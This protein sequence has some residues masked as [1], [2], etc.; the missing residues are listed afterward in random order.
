DSSIFYSRLSLEAAKEASLLNKVLDAG[1]LLSSLFKTAHRY[2][3]AF[4]YQELSI[5]IKDSLFNVERIKQ[6]QKMGFQEQ[7]RQQSIENARLEYGNKI[8]LYLVLVAL[9]VFLL[10]GIILMRKNI[11]KQKANVILQQQKEKVESTLSE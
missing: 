4:N 8:K 10:F 6:I 2:D 11:G 9:T 1:I 7:Q 5:K 3:S